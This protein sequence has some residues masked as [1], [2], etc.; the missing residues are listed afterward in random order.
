MR[1]V[2]D[3]LGDAIAAIVRASRALA[4]NHLDGLLENIAVEVGAALMEEEA[5]RGRVSG[6]AH[7]SGTVVSFPCA[8]PRV[9]ADAPAAA[10]EEP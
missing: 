3:R 9:A 6:R 10:G 4:P 5:R 2:D 7:G 1:D 8:T